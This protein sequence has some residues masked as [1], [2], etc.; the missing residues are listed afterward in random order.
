MAKKLFC[1][2]CGAEFS[3]GDRFC[4]ECG[5]KIEPR[6]PQENVKAVSDVET[7]ETQIQCSC[8]GQTGEN[9]EPAIRC[10]EAR[11]YESF[12][13]FGKRGIL[14]LTDTRLMF[15]TFAS[16]KEIALEIFLKDIV[17]VKKLNTHSAFSIGVYL[18]D[19]QYIF[20]SFQCPEWIK[21]IN[22][23][24]NAA[25]NGEHPPVKLKTD[26]I[27]EIKRLKELMDAGI[28]TEAEFTAKKKTLL[29]L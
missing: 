22:N 27:D 10:G 4:V 26:Y 29:G 17:I 3:E 7:G 19:K 2:K 9:E 6:M 21:Q 11:Y 18:K 20:H 16:R 12:W 5:N 15:S 13:T 1:P 14:S 28:I 24:V 8:V 23:A 25:K